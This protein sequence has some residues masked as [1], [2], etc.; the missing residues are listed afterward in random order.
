L[1][2]PLPPLPSGL[3]E[4]SLSSSVINHISFYLCISNYCLK[5][6]DSN[7]KDEKI[8]FLGTAGFQLP[9]FRMSYCERPQRES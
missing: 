6:A 1:S 7:S 8:I 2:Y 3:Y 9:E 5:L 4:L